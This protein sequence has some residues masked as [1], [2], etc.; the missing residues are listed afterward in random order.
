MVLLISWIVVTGLDLE[1]PFCSCK[2]CIQHCK[3]KVIPTSDRLFNLHKLLKISFL[4]VTAMSMLLLMD[5]PFH[6]F[7]Y[8]NISLSYVVVCIVHCFPLAL[9]QKFRVA[10]LYFQLH[11]PLHPS[12]FFPEVFLNQLYCSCLICICIT[13]LRCVNSSGY[14]CFL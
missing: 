3:S 11:S 5:L 10:V 8:Y 14:C 6:H 2:A 9:A 12:L 13:T 4:W 7:L 1:V